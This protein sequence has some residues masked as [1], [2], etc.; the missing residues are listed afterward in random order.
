[1]KKNLNDSTI[2]LAVVVPIEYMVSLSLQTINLGHS[3]P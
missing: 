1:M 2:Q 3:S